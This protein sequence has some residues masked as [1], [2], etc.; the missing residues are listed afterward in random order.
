MGFLPMVRVLT[1]VAQR[2]TIAP[3]KPLVVV[4]LARLLYEAALHA[5]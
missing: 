4:S 3:A 1:H 2:K 5:A